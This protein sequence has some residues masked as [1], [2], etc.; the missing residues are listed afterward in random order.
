MA[1][2]R[3][4]MPAPWGAIELCAEDGELCGVRPLLE[5]VPAPS[6]A[7]EGIA[8]MMETIEGL[9][10]TPSATAPE[11]RQRL[12]ALAAF[13]RL[14]P[15]AQQVLAAASEIEPGA[16]LTYTELARA[17]GSPAGARAAGQALAH[18]PFPI[19]IGCHRVCSAAERTHF[20]ILKPETFRPKA[21]MGEAALAGVAQW[22]RL[23][24]LSL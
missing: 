7:P 8:E 22:L 16:W 17:A 19:L 13:K 10:A 11:L 6:S 14:T 20:D 12:F 2:D 1:V 23:A 21:Y 15:F 5:S 3:Y 24:D 4:R 9:L 18:N